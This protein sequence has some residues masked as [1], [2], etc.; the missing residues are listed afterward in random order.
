MGLPDIILLGLLMIMCEVLVQQHMGRKFNLQT[1]E[2]SSVTVSKLNSTSNSTLSVTKN[3]INI[4][5]YFRCSTNKE[6]DKRVSRM[7]TMKIHNK[8]SGIFV[9]ISCF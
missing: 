7:L 3:C 5:N 2:A 9:G 4:S 8:F 6:A 1:K